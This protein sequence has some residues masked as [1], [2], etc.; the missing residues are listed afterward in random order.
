MEGRLYTAQEIFDAIQEATENLYDRSDIIRSLVVSRIGS[1]IAY[2]VT[3]IL[4]F[5]QEK[6]LEYCKKKLEQDDEQED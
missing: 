6:V 5:D 4:N 2:E 3:K 1:D